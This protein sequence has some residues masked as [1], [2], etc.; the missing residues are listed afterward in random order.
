MTLHYIIYIHPAG[1]VSSCL[2]VYYVL[3]FFFRLFMWHGWNEYCFQT[4]KRL[5]FIHTGT[6]KMS[7]DVLCVKYSP[8]QKLIAVSL[9]D[10]TVKV[11][12]TR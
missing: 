2:D 3:H 4:A 10:C 9:L 1:I 11:C 7:D 6:L 8:D 12:I 5:G